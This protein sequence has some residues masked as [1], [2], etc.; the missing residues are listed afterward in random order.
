M[1]LGSWRQ[2]TGLRYRTER[3]DEPAM[4][5]A[6]TTAQVSAVRGTR[7]LS[8]LGWVLV[9]AAAL[10]AAV[11]GSGFSAVVLSHTQQKLSAAKAMKARADLTVID[12]A[13]KMYAIEHEGRFPESLID[14]SELNGGTLDWE[15]KID[16]WE[17]PYQYVPPTSDRPWPRLL[18]FGSDG[19]P[20]GIGDAAD[21]DYDAIKAA[22]EK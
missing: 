4:K 13:V 11:I 7:G 18:C 10:G 16:P 17:H 6:M 1:A 8:R 3:R 14:A 21:I 9:I 19:R 12:A 5:K 15:A 20:G 22:W 2:A